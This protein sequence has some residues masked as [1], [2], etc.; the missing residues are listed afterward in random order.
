MTGLVLID[1]DVSDVDALTIAWDA[2]SGA[3]LAPDGR[4]PEAGRGRLCE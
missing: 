4:R 1:E 3:H 2:F